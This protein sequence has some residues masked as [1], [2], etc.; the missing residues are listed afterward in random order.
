MGQSGAAQDIAR[1]VLGEDGGACT[2]EGDDDE[3]QEGFVKV[4]RTVE[5]LEAEKSDLRANRKTNKK[6]VKEANAEKRQTKLKKKDKKRAIK[7]AKAGN[8]KS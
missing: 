8:R 7:K 6:A 5:E 1:D 3:S 2:D 4:P